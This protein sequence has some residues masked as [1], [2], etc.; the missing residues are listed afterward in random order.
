MISPKELKIMHDD[1]LHGKTL[2][3][4][5]YNGL[6]DHTKHTLKRMLKDSKCIL[7]DGFEGYIAFPENP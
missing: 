3:I 1:L 7:T 6:S 2:S 5:E 4:T